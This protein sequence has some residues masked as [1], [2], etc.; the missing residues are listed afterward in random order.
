MHWGEINYRVK[1]LECWVLVL[2]YRYHRLMPN[3][4]NNSSNWFCDLNVSIK[5]IASVLWLCIFVLKIVF[6]VV[7]DVT[8]Y[9]TFCAILFGQV[10]WIFLSSL[11]L[12]K[13]LDR[14]FEFA[15]SM[16]I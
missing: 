14:I 13:H 15:T 6:K 1:L 10:K 4:V 3:T 7:R 12:N 8:V 11:L 2:C 9:Y 16:W 5:L